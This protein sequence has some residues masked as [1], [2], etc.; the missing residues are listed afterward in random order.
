MEIKVW[1]SYSD[2]KLNTQE[3]IQQ[4]QQLIADSILATHS[5]REPADLEKILIPLAK[6]KLFWENA[7]KRRK[8]IEKEQF[9]PIQQLIK[10]QLEPIEHTSEIIKEK[11]LALYKIDPKI[12][13]TIDNETGEIGSKIK[14]TDNKG[15]GTFK[16]SPQV[17]NQEIAYNKISH[18]THPEFFDMVPVLN[19]DRVL[20]FTRKHGI[21]AEWTETII[22]PQSCQI[23]WAKLAK[24][25]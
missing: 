10:S 16:Y 6:Q 25:E 14:L 3:I 19:R 24:K 21:P 5:A 8:E 23:Q 12:T 15:T 1:N 17:I 11:F 22:E 18:Q 7:D 4:L 2:L 20:D 9:K 13:E